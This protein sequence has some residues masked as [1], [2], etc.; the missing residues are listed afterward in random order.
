MI[1]DSK[2]AP[3]SFARI[4]SNIVRSCAVGIASGTSNVQVC[5]SSNSRARCSAPA[6]LP[7]RSRSAQTRANSM[8]SAKKTCASSTARPSPKIEASIA[9]ARLRGTKGRRSMPRASSCQRAAAVPKRRTNGPC[10][11]AARSPSR[12]IPSNA[13][14]ST[15]LV[16]ISSSVRGSS[17]SSSHSEP[18]SQMLPSAT[19]AA[20]RAA[21]LFDPAPSRSTDPKPAKTL[22]A[23]IIHARASPAMPCISRKAK[24]GRTSSISGETASRAS[25]IS[26]HSSGKSNVNAK[27]H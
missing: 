22:R 16:S 9:M 1:A 14:R 19:Y 13:S 15:T 2:V 6:R 24:P 3:S 4:I 21:I 26:S 10:G 23:C 7:Q 17:A 8:R 5:A 11:N 27:Q 20:A 18:G 12:S 25:S